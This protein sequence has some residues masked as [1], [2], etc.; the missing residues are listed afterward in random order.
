MKSKMAIIL[1]LLVLLSAFTVGFASDEWKCPTCETVS[2]GNFCPEC[3]TAK[4]D[5]A[6]GIP[7]RIV[8]EQ[9]ILPDEEVHEL[10]RG[11]I[12]LDLAV[13]FKGNILFSKYDVD[14]YLDD[15]PV[16]SLSHGDDFQGVLGVTEGIHVLTLRKKGSETIKGVC[17]FNVEE[18][19]SYSCT[20]KCKKKIIFISREKLGS[21]AASF[22]LSE[23]DYK[24]ACKELVY[25]DIERNP[26]SFSGIKAKLSGKVIEAQEGWFN[27]VTM[28]IMD[29]NTD[30]WYV[31][32][33]RSN[34][35]D[36]ILEGDHV[37]VYGECK[38]CA[39][40]SSL[41]RGKVTIPAVNAKYMEIK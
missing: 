7:D 33:T 28:R 41:L 18:N 17:Q 5:G 8:D 16:V 35:E 38:G 30:I 26:D 25:K 29:P 19:T 15:I 9:M 36:R 13:N 1:A 2:S 4:P 24:A 3:G 37:T 12:R 27:V 23:E 11:P 32:Y 39:T 34:G 40:Y 14:V 10:F 22:S 21:A 31:T 20:I 6:E